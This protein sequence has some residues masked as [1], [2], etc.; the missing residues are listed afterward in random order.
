[1]QVGRNYGQTDGQGSI[2]IPPGTFQGS[3]IKAN[4]ARN[5][6]HQHTLTCNN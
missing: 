3:S 2:T 1:M 6:L 4:V 5:S